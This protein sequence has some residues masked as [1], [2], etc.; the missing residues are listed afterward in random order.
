MQPYQIQHP[1]AKLYRVIN[2][3][4]GETKGRHHSVKG[5]DPPILHIT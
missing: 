5:Q 1:G 4:L 3:T 2:P